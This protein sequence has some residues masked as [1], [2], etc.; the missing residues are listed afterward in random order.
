MHSLGTNEKFPP[1]RQLFTF[2]SWQ[3]FTQIQCLWI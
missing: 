3:S 2:T 1:Q